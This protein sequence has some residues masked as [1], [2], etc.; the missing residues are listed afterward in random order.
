[1]KKNTCEFPS[2]S[3]RKSLVLL[4]KSIEFHK[5]PK[6]LSK[7]SSMIRSARY[8]NV[9]NSIK[10]STRINQLYLPL[11][12]HEAK[13]ETDN[14]YQDIKYKKT[15]KSRAKVRRS[16]AT[17]L[18][19]KQK[20]NRFPG[21]SAIETKASAV[22]HRRGIEHRRSVWSQR[23]VLQISSL[24][25]PRYGLEYE[26]LSICLQCEPNNIPPNFAQFRAVSL[27]LTYNSYVYIQ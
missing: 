14:N 6:T 26:L 24:T 25:C 20:T 10:H 2:P 9:G 16:L 8:D 3:S 23:E 12:L 4:G 19:Y 27:T 5:Q 22:M 17:A 15:T 7:K 11:C 1:M 13:H 21:F 18:R